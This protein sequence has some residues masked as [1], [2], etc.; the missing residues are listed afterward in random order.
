MIRTRR[1]TRRGFLEHSSRLVAAGLLAPA[2]VRSGALKAEERPAANERVGV[3]FIGVGGRGAS[4]LNHYADN[5]EFPTVAVC[6]VDQGMRE[7]AAKRLAPQVGRHNDYRELLD[8]KDV[9]AVVIAVPDHWHAIAA[10]Q[11]CEAGKDVYCEKPL[12]LTVRQGRAMV[13]AARRYGRVFQTGSQQRSSSNFR[14]AC[15]LVRSG[16]LGKIE[17]IRVSVWGS[18]RPCHLPAEPVPPGLDWN[19]WI[20]PAPWR[21]FHHEIHPFH[22]RK[23]RDFSGGQMTDWGAHHLDIAQWA[24]GMDA[25]GPVKILPPGDGKE[26]ITYEYAS[27]VTVHCES[28]GVNGVEFVG[29]DGRITVNRGF[30]KAEPGEVAREPLGAGDFQLYRSP[31][32]TQ[33]WQRCLSSRKK[34]ICDVE[35]GHRSATVCHLGNIALWTGRALSWDPVKEKIVGDEQASRWLDRP[36]RAPPPGR[37]SW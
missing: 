34:P 6:D 26:Y 23:F 28:V 5:A 14:E 2:I 20:G 11:S 35:I 10:I 24:L 7:K 8:R 30:F 25:S 32:H 12:S 4:L 31:G 27:G 13:D 3:G 18:S 21:P 15:E 1:T 9:D 22:W 17:T 29:A 37:S 36:L 16:R 19:Q 33:D